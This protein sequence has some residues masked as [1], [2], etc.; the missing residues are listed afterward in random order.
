M[1]LEPATISSISWNVAFLQTDDV[2]SDISSFRVA[3]N[4]YSPGGR[5][6]PVLDFRRRPSDFEAKWIH[7]N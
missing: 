6:H 2:T 5:L 1:I 7:E 4:I 3:R